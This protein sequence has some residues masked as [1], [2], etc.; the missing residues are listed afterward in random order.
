VKGKDVLIG[1]FKGDAGADYALVVNKLHGMKKSSSE[2][3]DEI[4]LTFDA[5]TTSVRAESWLD[6]RTGDV[7][8]K[9]GKA[10]LKIAGGTGVLLRATR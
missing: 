10:S 2:T 7:A 8:L 9:D 1:F 6:G 4:E 3:A 5:K